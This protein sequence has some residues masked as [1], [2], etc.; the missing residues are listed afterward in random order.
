MP[1]E[2][3]RKELYD[4]LWARPMIKVA[5]EYGLSDVGLKKICKKHRV[6]DPGRGYWA[7]KAAGKPVKQ[8]HFSSID[9][10][11]IERVV[12][13][14]GPEQRLTKGVKAAAHN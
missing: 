13:R 11:L 4:Q 6:P 8:K 12:I 2:V 3:T 5:A 14:G 1:I 10:P 7:K 9:D